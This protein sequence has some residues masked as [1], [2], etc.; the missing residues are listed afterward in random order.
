MLEV[1]ALLGYM[2]NLA[3]PV[4]IQGIYGKYF[5]HGIEAWCGPSVGL[6]HPSIGIL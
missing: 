1:H 4:G 2:A 5:T 3:C 6:C